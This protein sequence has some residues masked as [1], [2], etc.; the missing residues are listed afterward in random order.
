EILPF[1]FVSHLIYKL[2]N[3]ALKFQNYNINATTLLNKT[4][5][6]YILCNICNLRAL[7]CN[8]SSKIKETSTDVSLLII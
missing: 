8:I 2:Y 7:S 3:T 5:L 1:V 6:Y 4:A